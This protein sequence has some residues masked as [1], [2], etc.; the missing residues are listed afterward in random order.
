ME[1]M[2]SSVLPAAEGQA[3]GTADKT[4]V[5]LPASLLEG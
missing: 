2:D 5:E 1:A 3:F 4:L